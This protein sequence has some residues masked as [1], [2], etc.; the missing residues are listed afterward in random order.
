MSRQSDGTGPEASLAC[1]SP[2]RHLTFTTTTR[3]G[4]CEGQAL[5]RRWIDEPSPRFCK[6]IHPQCKACSDLGRV[7]VLND[8]PERVLARDKFLGSRR[9]F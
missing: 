5:D 3:Q 4:G 9:G 7:L 8:P 1:I 6:I 2:P